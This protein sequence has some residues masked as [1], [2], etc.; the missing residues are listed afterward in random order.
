MKSEVVRAVVAA[1][2]V[3][4]VACT[5]V[6]AVRLPNQPAAPAVPPATD[7]AAPPSSSA[8]LD[9]APEQA[10]LAIGHLVKVTLKSGSTQ[11]L[12]VASIGSDSFEGHAE[13]S[14]VKVQIDFK[15]VSHIEQTRIDSAKTLTVIAVVAGVLVIL[16]LAWGHAVAK[17]F[18]TA[19]K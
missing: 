2:C 16:G 10:P 11:N 15:D 5:T 3:S 18:G 14:S 12:V 9:A 17:S 7:T 13:N 8:Q 4:L 1:C 6:Q 19:A